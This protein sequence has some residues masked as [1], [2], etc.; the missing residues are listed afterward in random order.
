MAGA[1]GIIAL[2]PQLCFRVPQERFD[3]ALK[4]HEFEMRAFQPWQKGIMEYL[5]LWDEGKLPPPSLIRCKINRIPS[6][7]LD[8]IFRAS[9]RAARTT[10]ISA[11]TPL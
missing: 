9:P 10:A 3:L 11:A 2:A 4:M 6:S 7:V 1:L 8:E 5:R